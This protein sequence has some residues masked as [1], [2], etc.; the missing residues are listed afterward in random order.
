[1]WETAPKLAY[2]K[3][4]RVYVEE[5]RKTLKATL[6]KESGVESI[7]AQEREAYAHEAYKNHLQALKEAVQEEEMLRWRMVTDQASVDVWRSTEAS[8]RAMDKGTQ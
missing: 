7:G 6:M 3:A 2:A 5:Y 1:M 8:N 4:N